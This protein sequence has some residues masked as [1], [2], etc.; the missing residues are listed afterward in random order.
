MYVCVCVCVRGIYFSSPFSLVHWHDLPLA[1][2]R[3]NYN[4]VSPLFAHVLPVTPKANQEHNPALVD[5][6]KTEYHQLDTDVSSKR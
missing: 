3:E 1:G 4:F 2:K 5:V 6:D